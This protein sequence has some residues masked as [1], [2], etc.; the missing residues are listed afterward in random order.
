MASI[1]TFTYRNKWNTLMAQA[2]LLSVDMSSLR[3]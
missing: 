2:Y 1:I 3:A